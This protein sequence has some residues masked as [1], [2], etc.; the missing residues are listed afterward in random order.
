MPEALEPTPG[1]PLVTYVFDL[2][3]GRPHMLTPEGR[4]RVP[5][6]WASELVRLALPR[7]RL[8]HAAELGAGGPVLFRRLH[9]NLVNWSS[10]VLPSEDLHPPRLRRLVGPHP[11]LQ[12]LPWVVT[13]AALGLEDLEE[14]YVLL[15][16]R[17][18]PAGRR[19]E[20]E[21]ELLEGL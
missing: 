11:T 6:H 1:D 10:W 3:P 14:P 18:R 12:R 8:L 9:F 20:N 13:K 15:L 5:G 21:K 19:L 16:R 2:H 7:V 4:F 17:S